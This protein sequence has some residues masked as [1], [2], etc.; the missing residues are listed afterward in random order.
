MNSIIR[1]LKLVF[2]YF[3][4]F[5][6]FSIIAGLFMQ[7][8]PAFFNSLFI[9]SAPVLLI[10]WHSKR[11]NLAQ[12]SPNNR[13]KKESKGHRESKSTVKRRDKKHHHTPDLD[14][15]TESLKSQHSNTDT[16]ASQYT[17]PNSQLSD[18]TI[19]SWIGVADSAKVAGRQI[20]GLIYVGIPPR[21]QTRGF[22]ETCR[23]YIDPSVSVAHSGADIEG[24]GLNY[25]PGYTSIAPPCR[26]AYLDWLSSGRSDTSYNVGYM[27][28][29]FYGLERRFFLDQT[30][31]EEKHVII[32]EVSRLRTLYNENRSVQ[33]YLSEF[34]DVAQL[35]TLKTDNLEPVL[36]RKGWEIPLTVKFSIGSMINQQKPLN[37]DWFLSWFLCH[38]ESKLRKAA[39]RCR[40]EFHALFKIRFAEKHPD[41]LL[42][43]KPKKILKAS[44]SAAS[45][46]FETTVDLTENGNP[47][48]DISGLR[49]Q[50]NLAQRIADGVMEDLDKLSRFLGRNVDKRD[51]VEAYALMPSELWSLFP[52]TEI[53]KLTDWASAISDKGGLT[54]LASVIEQLEGTPPEKISKRQLTSAADALARIGFGLAPDPR[55]ALRSPKIDEPV[56]L[57]ELGQPVEKL[58]TVS[59]E[60]RSALLILAIGSFVAFADGNV[61]AEEEKTLKT[62]I[63]STDRISELERRRL[64]ANLQWFLAVPPDLTLLRRKLKNIETTGHAE[65]RSAM[66]AAAHADGTIKASEVAL[67]EKIY[68][69]LGMDSSQAYSDLHAGSTV[70]SLKTIRPAGPHRSGEAIPPV[71]SPKQSQTGSTLSADRI[72]TIRADTDRVSSVLGKI[73]DNQEESGSSEENETETTL[74]GLIEQHTAVVRTLLEKAHWT[75]AEFKQLC[76]DHKLLASGTL[77]S[78][79]EWAFEIH[80]D[81]LLD[82][83]NGYDLNIGIAASIKESL[84]TETQNV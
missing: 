67:M 60:Y 42:V 25:W 40:D 13:A 80:G 16:E 75:E 43:N 52:S 48:P 9:I 59:D 26:A 74:P 46:E 78:V 8:F 30:S 34:L 18:H 54:P 6:L 71:D 37:G 58:E 11:R 15:E 44:Y 19:D 73:F 3:L 84:N 62:H 20:G 64:L 21:V 79:N 50:V 77:E 72:A 14:F 22:P 53:I 23:A 2:L 35:T 28:I 29:Y 82:E 31:A 81:A 4:Y 70:D 10:L 38:P 41:G 51:S 39:T 56:V 61:C 12:I 76:A 66:V 57:F 24:E 5:I 49:K 32:D 63:L 36:D 1:L 45:T 68:K 7:K 83:Y 55:Y 69:T 27:F 17:Q 47:I 33:R 65:L